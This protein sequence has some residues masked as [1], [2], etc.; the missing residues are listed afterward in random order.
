MSLRLLQFFPLTTALLF[1]FAV[2]FPHNFVQAERSALNRAMQSILASDLKDH[3]DRLADDT[4]EGRE[5]GARGGQAAAGYIVNRLRQLQ[6]APAGNNGSYFQAFDSN[7]R[8][9]LG[10]IEGSDPQLKQEVIVVGAHYDHVGYG[11]QRNS[12]GPWGFIHN[13]A[14]DNA[15]GTAALL[16]I[17]EAFQTAELKPKRSVLI[18][19]WDAEEK[20]LLGSQ[21]WVNQPTV[22]LER[23]KCCLN[24]DMIGRLKSDKLEIYGVRSA[25]GLRELVSQANTDSQLD[26]DFTWKMKDDS[27][28]WSF[29]QRNIPVLMFHTGLHAEYHRPSDDAHLINHAG[30]E[31]I[32]RLV[33][34]SLMTLTS[35]ER[36][37]IFR[38]QARRET[39]EV[40]RQK[41][42]PAAGPAPR[43]GLTWKQQLTPTGAELT[44]LQVIPGTAA[45]TAGVLP[46]DVIHQCN[47]EPLVNEER[48]R[49]QVLTTHEPLELQLR[50]ENQ[51]LQ[52]SVSLNGP[53]VRIGLS[54]REDAAE[55]Q[56]MIVSHVVYGSAAHAAGLQV[57]DRIVQCNAN[58]C[59][60]SERFGEWLR[61]QTAAFELL[62]ERRGKHLPITVSLN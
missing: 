21:H 62:I 13:G 7:Y 15:S 30:L 48:F 34:Q 28:H 43:L 54:W 37:P 18:A 29:F 8:N 55:P 10:Y 24:A 42:H 26:L 19:F 44:V 4:F 25:A 32:T 51:P 40:Q 57:N 17:A 27:D 41:E 11:S 16:E 6:L 9:I 14:D 56:V 58:H 36:H 61:S 45:H 20:G 2:L 38:N 1:H 53:P 46:G 50:R 33:M 49:Q 23:V 47:A 52:I 31:R 3:V 12:Y 22:P 60:S 39:P 5:S 59:T 35:Q